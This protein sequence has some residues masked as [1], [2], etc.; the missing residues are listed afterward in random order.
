M[1]SKLF[2]IAALG[3]ILSCSSPITKPFLSGKKG[4]SPA[5]P[6]S[7]GGGGGNGTG[8]AGTDTISK[9]SLKA[10][11]DEIVAPTS[12][13]CDAGVDKT[14]LPK[15]GRSILRLMTRDEY[16]NTVRDVFGLN[17]NFTE[18]LS[19]EQKILG[20]SNNSTINLVGEQALSSYIATA[21]D[22]AKTALNE[23]SNLVCKDGAG[24]AEKILASVGSQAWRRPMEADEKA[25]LL[26]LFQAASADGVKIGLEVML[27]GLLTSPQFLY[28]SEMGKDGKL[29]PY[30]VASAL[31]YFFWATT[32]DAE[33]RK[34]AE[35]GSILDP[36][37]MAAQAQRLMSNER[38]KAG[39]NSF[40][41]A[42]LAYSNVSNISKNADRFK[43]F[44]SEVRT[45]MTS[46][47]RDTFDY[48]LRKKNSKFKDIF[49]AQQSIVDD[50]LAN[51][52]GSQT[53][54]ADN[55]KVID[56]SGSQRQ[57]VLGFGAILA[58]LAT[59]DESHPIK[60]GI[61]IRE[62]LLCETMAPTPPGLVIAIPPIKAGMTT[63]ERFAVH[64]SNAACSSC[65]N[66]IDG[67][68]FGMEDFDG[69]GRFR[70]KD[71]DKPV[72]DS[73]MF[74]GLDGKD[75]KFNGVQG[76]SDLLKSSDRAKRCFVLQ[77]FRQAA[78]RFENKADVCGIRNIADD[79]I[80][81]DKSLS[82]VFL[83]VI[84]NPVY[85]ERG[86]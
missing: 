43:D 70:E 41:D 28:R 21:R 40:S 27:T 31:S 32:P 26:A 73:G 44:T 15:E 85:H 29:T 1:M 69:V 83:N 71:G 54:Q 59:A 58:L 11:A 2:S 4:A 80:K 79:F 5:E 8:D 24:C 35:D 84:T 13:H 33:L 77:V 50:N 49:S 67:V 25:R 16:N 12:D 30:E 36:K 6:G 38:A 56:F 53:T 17:K 52:Y 14:A 74:V 34:A 3:L 57:G 75:Q 62:H 51:F 66:L 60:R 22:V 46:E 82:E 10:L 9:E 61:Y 55:V 48:W 23:T 7:Q 18:G 20:F 63:R 37:V 47:A 72:D 64:T 19:V 78:G 65:H 86:R 42:Y 68:G 76:M 39:V 45:A 81:S